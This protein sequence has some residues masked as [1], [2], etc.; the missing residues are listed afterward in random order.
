MASRLRWVAGA[1]FR[2]SAGV[3]IMIMI[4]KLAAISQF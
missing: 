2:W 3:F 1:N 4:I